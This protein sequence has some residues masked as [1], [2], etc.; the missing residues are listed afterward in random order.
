MSTR[1]P[2]FLGRLAVQKGILTREQLM[3]ALEVHESGPEARRF[4]AVL[5][6]MG[7]VSQ[8]QLAELVSEQNR[9]V[10][11][12][13]AKRG[14][15]AETGPAAPQGPQAPSPSA[16]PSPSQPGVASEAPMPE[17]APAPVAA[18]PQPAKASLAPVAA[19][20]STPEAPP[21]PAAAAPP[22]AT[23][24]PAPAAAAA[25][26]AGP[27]LRV[28]GAPRDPA[29]LDALLRQA[30]D[31]GASDIHVHSGA[32]VQLRLA[33][34]LTA[35]GSAVSPE[36]AEALLLNALS[37]EDAALLLERGELDVCHTVA[38]VGRFRANLYRQQGGLD[39]VFRHVPPTP[40]GFAE[41]GLPETLEKFVD[42]HQGMV[43][44][45]GPTG[46][47][48]TSTLA[49]LLNLVNE[50]R[51][52]HILTVEDPIEY[53]HESK[54]ALVNQRSVERHTGSFARALRAALREDP[55]VIV[56]GELRDLETIS[57]A[58][59][60]A[61]TGHFVLATLHTGSSIRTINRLVGAFPS[62]Q[63]DQIRTMISE[64]LR[65]VISQRL[66]PRADGQGRVP[67]LE[68]LVVNRAVANLIRENKTFQI[69]S[70]L[71]TG[72]KQGMI[73]LEQ[74]VRQLLSEG[75]IS[76]DEANQHLEESKEK[77][78]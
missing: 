22:T 47:G 73:T 19:A 75:T 65:A 7:F 23:Q 20:P 27:A 38:G 26:P 5:V 31:R 11:Q 56:I 32:P 51:P 50:R 4:G 35:E 72:T 68:T 44:V 53:V 14:A 76:E 49:A 69:Q 10:E 46:C 58:L 62:N 54:R 37:A 33:G 43:L 21:T 48:K 63:Q 3:A 29:A 24:A 64:S 15:A 66:I 6:E 12:I 55:D 70:I 17:A 36:H 78:A 57:L 39:G 45:T 28:S 9:L 71:Q 30:V 52:D 25:A 74:S 8:P 60:A 41:L 1:K 18:V 61:E 34:A 67:A 16:Q 40:P 2:P 77:A 42:Y 59:T 13:R